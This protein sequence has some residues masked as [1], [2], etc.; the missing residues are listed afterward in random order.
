M[1]DVP[2]SAL[3]GAAVTAQALAGILADL[4]RSLPLPAAQAATLATTCRR[5]A[6]V[7]APRIRSSADVA[8]IA[9]EL[10]TAAQGLARNV[11]PGDAA[12]ALYAAAG[13]ASASTPVSASPVLTRAYALARVLAVGIEAACLGEA[14]LA[15]AR[16]GFADRPSATQAR[17]RIDT[18]MAGAS[19][20]IAS[21]LGE[22]PLS[23]LAG[24]ARQCS[25]VLAAQATTLQPV[26]VVNAMRSFPSGALAWSLYADPTR[27]AEL[28]RRNAVGTPLFMPA[29]LEALTP[30]T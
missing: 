13:L 25:T 28:V 3:A 27:A 29:T 6:Q 1:F 21:T 16:S 30:K 24:A 12:A 10:I 20:R 9:A 14:F 8:A 22:G 7:A 15:E 19:D 11:A 17:A 18:A 5:T 26:S 2:S 4:T 23:I